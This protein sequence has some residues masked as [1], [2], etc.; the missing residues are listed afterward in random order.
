V[1]LACAHASLSH[2]AALTDGSA[3]D[4]RISYA[5][6]IRH[7][8]YHVENAGGGETYI[9]EAR[10][11]VSD[12]SW[13]FKDAQAIDIT[14]GE[15]A[16]LI[17]AAVDARGGFAAPLSDLEAAYVA[18]DADLRAFTEG[19]TDWQGV[20]TWDDLA[21]QWDAASS[22]DRDE[23]GYTDWEEAAAGTDPDNTLDRPLHGEFRRVADLA[24]EA[25]KPQPI[26][27]A[28]GQREGT[29]LAVEFESDSEYLRLSWVEDANGDA[30]QW[31]YI[32]RDKATAA[33]IEHGSGWP[34]HLLGG[35]SPEDVGAG[36]ASVFPAERIIPDTDPDTGEPT[37]GLV[38]TGGLDPNAKDKLNEAPVPG[39]RGGSIAASPAEDWSDDLA[40]VGEAIEALR[41]ANGTAADE[42]WAELRAI[43]D[44]SRIEA[45][46]TGN[47]EL[48]IREQTDDLLDALGGGGATG[49]GDGLD[50]DPT[51]ATPDGTG[52]VEAP[53]AVAGSGAFASDYLYFPDPTDYAPVDPFSL[54]IDLP[55]GGVQTVTVNLA[56]IDPLFGGSLEQL[57]VSMRWLMLFGVVVYQLGILIE[58]SAQTW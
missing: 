7:T 22:S 15:L 14:A 55:G 33:T 38:I 46:A 37:G 50:I 44:A 4:V 1:G 48:A 36:L 3:L 41:Q 8:R 26:Y 43:R 20:A 21:P 9:G 13:T 58:R 16:A 31:A 42:L 51:E 47:V 40:G 53:P 49:G 32:L 6:G 12:D 23:D 57:R 56:A 19:N 34:S 24:S 29:L 10:L 54:D 52:E 30:S 5:Y 2:A 35:A 11:K 28:D 27:D 17:A 39:D 25:I 45:G 18:V